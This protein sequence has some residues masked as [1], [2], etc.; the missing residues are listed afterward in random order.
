MAD[1]YKHLKRKIRKDR[2]K[3]KGCTSKKSYDT[4]EEAFQKGQKTYKCKY[5][6]KFHRSGKMSKFLYEMGVRKKKV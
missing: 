1:K 2:R 3:E 5:C 4:K 6:G